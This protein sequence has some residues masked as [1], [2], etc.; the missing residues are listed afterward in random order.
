M[1]QGLAERGSQLTQDFAVRGGLLTQDLAERGNQL[2][3][4]LAERGG[5][6]TQE[7]AE[8]SGEISQ[9]LVKRSRK[10]SREL[11]EQD[12]SFWIVL[13]FTCGLVATGIVTFVLMRRRM[14]KSRDE[15]P[16][17]QL[18]SNTTEQNAASQPRG[19]IYSVSANGTRLE[20]QTVATTEPEKAG[21]TVLANR[22]V[23]KS[24]PSDAAFVGISNTKEY[25][26]IDAPL[27]QIHVS[28]GKEVDIVYFF[29][30]ED[31]QNQGFSAAA[32]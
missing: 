8:R 15:E 16:P 9:E 31:A 17:I 13:G 2:T 27:D 25:Y 26:P 7:L 19:N 32:R 30:E 20:A 4:S 21:R 14:Q 12:R 23:T 28:N 24:A 22:I 5:L 1:T 11:A 29:S 6:L 18:Y 3:Q 10:A